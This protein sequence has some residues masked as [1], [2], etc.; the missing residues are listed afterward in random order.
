[1]RVLVVGDATPWAEA[2]AREARA[3]RVGDPARGGVD[4]GPLISREARDRAHSTVR[5]AVAAGAEVLAG[6]APPDGPGW[7]YPPTVLLATTPDP[8]AALEGVFGP[9]VVVRGVPDAEA[10]VAAANAS[11]FGLAASVWS[12]DARAAASVAER[13]DAGMVS[14]NEVV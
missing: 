9:V 12:R 5:A 3:L 6:G 4:V 13:L 2:L 7:F 10:A 8:E 11:R 1:K 14:V